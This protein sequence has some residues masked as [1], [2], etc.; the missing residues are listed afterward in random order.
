MTAMRAANDQSACHTSRPIIQGRN[1]IQTTTWSG[2]QR[3]VVHCQMESERLGRDERERDERAPQA[4][5][6]DEEQPLH[7]ASIARPAARL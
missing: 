1:R 2:H 4:D 5:H 3:P 7:A 6:D